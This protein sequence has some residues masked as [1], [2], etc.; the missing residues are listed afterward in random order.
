MY[1]VFRLLSK[2]ASNTTDLRMEYLKFYVI[3]NRNSL[4][5]FVKEQHSKTKNLYLHLYL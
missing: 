3:L 1:M 2:G 4:H 5:G